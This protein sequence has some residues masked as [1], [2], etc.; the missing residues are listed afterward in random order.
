MKH[1][2]TYADVVRERGDILFEYQ[3]PICGW[4]ALTEDGLEQ[5]YCEVIHSQETDTDW[6]LGYELHIK[7]TCPKCNTEFEY[8]DGYP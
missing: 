8:M 4:D 1:R 2:K 5:G 7:C 6:G 3:C